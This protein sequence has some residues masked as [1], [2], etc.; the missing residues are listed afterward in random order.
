MLALSHTAKTQ[1]QNLAPGSVALESELITPLQGHGGNLALPLLPAS[2]AL[3]SA[4]KE[5]EFH[6]V[7]LIKLRNVIIQSLYSL[8]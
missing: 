3:C 2:M 7:C 5:A 6:L 4:P 1:I 8:T